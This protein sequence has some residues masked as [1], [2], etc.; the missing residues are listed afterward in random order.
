MSLSRQQQQVAASKPAIPSAAPKQLKNPLPLLRFIHPLTFY[1]TASHLI[2]V[3]DELI[4][5]YQLKGYALEKELYFDVNMSVNEKQAHITSLEIKTSP[6]AS[7][8]LSPFLKRY[9]PVDPY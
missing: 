3:N 1:S 9:I 2:P 8:E 5:H 4:R 7:A 6:W